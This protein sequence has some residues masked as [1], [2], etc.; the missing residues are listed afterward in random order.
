MARGSSAMRR[1]RCRPGAAG[2]IYRASLDGGDYGSDHCLPGHFSLATTATVCTDCRPTC[3]ATM[4]RHSPGCC[5]GKVLPVFHSS[6]H[7]VTNHPNP[8]PILIPPTHPSRCR[9]RRAREAAYPSRVR[10][11]PGHEPSPRGP[12][13][14]TPDDGG[15][16]GA[17]GRDRGRREGVDSPPPHLGTGSAGRGWPGRSTPLKRYGS[18]A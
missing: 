17:P 5:P 9:R 15:R 7:P 8:N 13:W 12:R 1:R 4:P 14:L 10:R 16:S 6:P 3:L 11:R 18:W 2:S